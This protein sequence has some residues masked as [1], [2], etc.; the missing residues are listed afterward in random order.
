RYKERSELLSVLDRLDAGGLVQVLAPIDSRGRLILLLRALDE[1]R[2]AEGAERE[3]Y[4][5]LARAHALAGRYAYEGTITGTLYGGVADAVKKCGGQVDK[6]G[7]LKLA[8]LKL[9]YRN[10]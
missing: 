4:L 9:Y 1:A 6:C 2:R 10:I 5:E 8:L 7:E 3:R